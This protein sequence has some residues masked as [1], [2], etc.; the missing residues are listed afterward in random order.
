MPELG[1]I[2][3]GMHKQ[4]GGRGIIL[5]FIIFWKN[6]SGFPEVEMASMA[7]EQPVKVFSRLKILP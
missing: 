3:T 2:D 5:G 4:I 7:S 1:V 6:L